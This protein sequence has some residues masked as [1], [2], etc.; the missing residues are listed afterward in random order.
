MCPGGALGSCG[1]VSQP[2]PQ[3]DLLVKSDGHPN[4][5][6]YFATEDVGQFIH[7][8]LERCECTLASEVALCARRREAAVHSATAGKASK[9]GWDVA[10][11]KAPPPSD[12]TRRFLLELVLGVAHLHRMRIIHRDLKPHNILLAEVPVEEASAVALRS[13]AYPEHHKFGVRWRA[14][15]SDMGLSKQLDDAASSFSASVPVYPGPGEAGGA[16]KRPD[17]TNSSSAHAV[18][19]SGWQAPEVLRLTTTGRQFLESREG[20][21]GEGWA[22]VRPKHPNRRV[23]DATPTDADV[24]ARRTRAVDVWGLGCVLYHVVN[25][26]G[27]PFGNELE[28][29]GNILMCHPRDLGLLAHVPDALDLIGRMIDPDPDRRPKARQVADHPF[30]WCDDVRMAFFQVSS[31]VCVRVMCVVCVCAC[32][33]NFDVRMCVRAGRE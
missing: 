22:P 29:N 26:G 13:P 12:A 16:P 25:A 14:K 17:T 33:H 8:V 2:S 31:C 32:M 1:N 30:F 4:V 3:I 24:A 9:R 18:G 28:R 5:V 6:R 27:H 11:V 10:L 23:G 21:S 20:P 19:T 7:L 15:I